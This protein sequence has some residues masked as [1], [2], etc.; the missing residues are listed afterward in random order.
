MSQVDV[1]FDD[2]AVISFN[3]AGLTLQHLELIIQTA[4]E[5]GSVAILNVG[6]TS[7]LDLAMAML[8]WAERYKQNA[9]A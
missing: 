7:F 9:G 2:R 5:Y 1:D 8:A 3:G 4:N 6:P